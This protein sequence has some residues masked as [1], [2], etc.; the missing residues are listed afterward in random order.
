MITYETIVDV[1]KSIWDKTKTWTQK[2]SE[3][4]TACSIAMVGGDLTVFSIK[5]ALTAAKTGSIAATVY[6]ISA[7]LFGV[8]N[9]FAQAWLIAMVTMCVDMVVHSTHY[10]NNYTEALYTGLGAGFIALMMSGVIY[11]DK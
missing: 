4:F 10:G 8:Q 6:V 11:R 2:A 3:S 5:H 1:S 9:R 7:G